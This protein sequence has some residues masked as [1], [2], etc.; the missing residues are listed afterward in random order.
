M[1]AFFIEDV[2]SEQMKGLWQTQYVF[3]CISLPNLSIIPSPSVVMAMIS[4]QI[5][6]KS[7]HRSV[8]NL[9]K[10]SAL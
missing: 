4:F 7:S 10:V 2:S 6:L 8:T 1:A 3:T 9:N 5:N